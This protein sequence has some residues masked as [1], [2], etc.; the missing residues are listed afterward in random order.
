MNCCCFA[1][2]TVVLILQV[3]AWCESLC[4]H[5]FIKKSASFTYHMIVYPLLVY[6][7]CDGNVQ[8]DLCN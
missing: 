4:Q 5:I 8:K 1:T 3:T 6:E 2:C 7:C